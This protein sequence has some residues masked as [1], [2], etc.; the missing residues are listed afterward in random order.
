MASSRS[1]AVPGRSNVGPAEASLLFT[2]LR[3]RTG[4]LRHRAANSC[5][6][7]LL[8]HFFSRCQ[9]FHMRKKVFLAIA[10]VAVITI[11]AWTVF[12]GEEEEPRYRGRPLS[13][14]LD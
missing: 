3:P 13:E 5:T 8:A 14:W 4:A 11:L 9:T 10:C 1:A 7:I 6:A 12:V 2:L